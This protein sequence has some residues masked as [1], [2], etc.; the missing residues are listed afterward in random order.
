MTMDDQL[1]VIGEQMRNFRLQAKLTLRELGAQAD[2]SP[3]LL[4]QIENGKVNPSVM[5]LQSIAAA[6]NA[7][8]ASFLPHQNALAVGA[9]LPMSSGNGVATHAPP[10]ESYVPQ[11][12]LRPHERSVLELMGG[13]VW[14][15]LTNEAV[16]GVEFL[17]IYYEPHASSGPVLSN[18]LG[19]EF[20]MVLE[21]VLTLQLGLEQYIMNAGDTI[22]FDSTVPHRLINNEDCDLRAI[23]VIFNSK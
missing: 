7:P 5:T 8:V 13:V 20:G 6:L 14:E 23:W 10:I 3:S 4:S 16:D 17:E 19:R 12:V 15:R 9:G 22:V 1:S 2:V 11:H 21:G 18:H